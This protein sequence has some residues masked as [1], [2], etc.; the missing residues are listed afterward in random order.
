MR[1][2]LASITPPPL[3][4]PVKGEGEDGGFS[5][6]KGEGEDMRRSPIEGRGKEVR[7]FPSMGEGHSKKPLPPRWGKAGMGVITALL[8]LTATPAAAALKIFACEPE[9]A[10]LARELGGSR[11][12][13][14]SATTALQDVHK[15][16]ARPSLIAKYRQA[17]LVV[18][19]GADLEIGWLP[20]LV[21][22]ANNPRVLPGSDGFLE[23]SRYVSMIEVPEVLD[24]AQG[25]VHP[26]GN[27]HIQ[28]DP[29]NITPVAAALAERLA[30]RDPAHAAD[31]R[32]RHAAF[33]A[34]WQSAV[35][36]WERKAQP[37]RGL[38]LVSTHK[39]WSYLNRWLGM[40]QVATLEPK[41]GIP[42]TAAHLSSVLEGLKTQPAAMILV[43]AYQDHKPAQWL[44]QRTGLPVIELPF[45]VGG[46]EGTEDLFKLFDVTLDRL[47][48]AAKP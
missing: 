28:T 29:R 46:V 34:R 42:P 2:K 7:P 36:E 14:Y 26:F 16:Q 15:I 21:E 25:D 47:L 6:V 37:L 39:D 33:A 43:A 41:P 5:P 13:A 31:Y 19:T 35:A 11:V 1:A 17:D 27:P 22:K 9:W 18:C 48:A 10:A 30:Q 12:E 23:A 24:R 38:R 4:S 32:Q 40:T 20:A 45:T 44:A 3:P 8:L